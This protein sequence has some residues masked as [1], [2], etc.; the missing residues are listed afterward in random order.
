M[1]LLIHRCQQIENLPVEKH[2]GVEGVILRRGRYVLLRRQNESEMPK[3]HR[4][5]FH[6]DGASDE[7]K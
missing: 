2:Q 1:L 6:E 7:R 4:P 3:S 5:L